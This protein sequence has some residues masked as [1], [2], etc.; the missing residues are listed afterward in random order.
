MPNENH[1]YEMLLRDIPLLFEKF[2]FEL[3]NNETLSLIA[4]KVTHLM[5]ETGFWDVTESNFNPV[6]PRVNLDVQYTDV[7]FDVDVRFPNVDNLRFVVS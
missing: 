7:G 2:L 6:I 5:Y 1:A 3:K 4:D